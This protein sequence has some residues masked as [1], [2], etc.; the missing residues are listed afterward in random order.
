MTDFNPLEVEVCALRVE[1][2]KA[3]CRIA[4]LVHLLKVHGGQPLKDG[5]LSLGELRT[6][7][8]EALGSHLTHEEQRTVEE[9]FT[10]LYVHFDGIE[11]VLR[12]QDCAC[13]ELTEGEQS[14]EEAIAGARAARAEAIEKGFLNA[15][16]RPRGK[17]IDLGARMKPSTARDPKGAA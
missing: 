11:R 7:I 17:V 1:L 4:D 3:N 15:T 8:L 12:A 5:I 10:V 13:G 2:A 16:D 14:L 6:R 9:T